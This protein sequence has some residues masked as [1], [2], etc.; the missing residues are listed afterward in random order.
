MAQ[1]FRKLSKGIKW[2]YKFDFHGNTYRSRYIYLSKNE[3][4]QAEAERLR[5]LD[6]KLRNPSEK[7]LLSLSE[8]M[9]DRLTQLQA[10]KGMKYYKMSKRYFKK[11]LH[12][13]NDVPVISITRD[14]I[15]KFLDSQSVLLRQKN[16]DN[17]SVNAMLRSYKALFNY[18]IDT[19]GIEMANPC[20]KISM[21]SVNKKI[22]YI[23]PDEDIWAVKKICTTEQNFLMDFIL[24]TGARINEPLRLKGKDILKDSVVLYTRKS[25]YSNLVPRKVILPQCLKGKNYESEERV[26]PWWNEQPKFLQRKIKELKQKPWGFHSLRHRRASLWN[27]EKKTVYDIMVL[28]G[29]SSIETTQIY[30]QMLS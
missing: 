30:L 4:K 3:A 26:F 5:E 17:Y 9:N 2:Q 20:R 10:K 19:K 21:Y 27:K 7:P 29:H 23:P 22:K 6:H 18:A 11:L 8:V 1:Y 14:H 13:L 16:K 24:E 25:K 28:L 12:Q 15:E